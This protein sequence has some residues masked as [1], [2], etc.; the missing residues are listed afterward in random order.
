MEIRTR[1]AQINPTTADIEG[2]TSL[3]LE[4]LECA[5][6]DGIDVVAFPELI[7]TGYCVLDLVEDDAFVAANR[8][9]LE[10]VRDQTGETVAVVG[11]IDRD[12]TGT[13]NAAAVLQNGEIKG[14]ARKVLLPN[15]RYFDDERYFDSGGPVS[16]VTVD[17]R[18]R[19]IDLGVAVCEDM[20]DLAYER[21]PIPELARAGAE[22]IVSVNASPFETGKRAVR[23]ETI[24]RHV[25]ETGLPFLYVNTIGAADVGRNVVVF[26]G[27]SLAYDARGTV[28]AKGEQFDNDRV[29][30]NL[31]PSSATSRGS[32][33]ELPVVPR[34][35][36]LYE[37]LVMAF[38][39]YAEKMDFETVIQPVGGGVDSALGLAIC[40]DA[41]G[42]ENVIA[43]CLPPTLDTCR[44]DVTAQLAENLGV[45]YHVVPTRS[46]SE[47]A[48]DV[49]GTHVREI[50]TDRAR[51]NVS[52][53]VGELLASLASEDTPANEPTMLVSNANETEL[54]LGY[55]TLS[56]DID[57]IGDLSKVDVYAVA[58]YVNERYGAEVLPAEVFEAPESTASVRDRG[59]TLDIRAAAPI[60]DALLEERC[61]PSELVAQFENGDLDPNRYGKDR[62][63]RTLY[64]RYDAETFASIVYET[65]RRLTTSTA[66]RVQA[67][68]VIAVSRRAFGA[69]F[70]EPIINEWDG[71]VP[72]WT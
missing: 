39:D 53:R 4:E 72:E 18:G 30:V 67:P 48:L 64:E 59:E 34:E 13:Y 24:R 8:T 27:D 17:I 21:K 57:P 10:H 69:D 49:Y 19:S 5:S 46:I 37:A 38:G 16:P 2:N 45:E 29:T 32:D 33:R 68:P 70:R 15:Y 51:E 26:D 31:D 50:E 43:Y 66:E 23:H 41:V 44:T 54:A 12:P 3:V 62:Q 35:R 14:I 63:G 11:F 56:G 40:V 22:V 36:E 25:A 9:A 55:V 60:V 20:W 1:L 61:G 6:A 42:S 28:L 71:R 47:E 58:E 7:I 52:K 65:Y